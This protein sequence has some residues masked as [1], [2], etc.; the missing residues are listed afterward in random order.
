MKEIEF[1]IKDFKSLQIHFYT[2]GYPQ[3]GEAILTII[4]DK[5]EV[6]FTS[7]TDCYK[8]VSQNY[9]HI[10]AILAAHGNPSV[11]VFIWTH[12]D[13]DHSIGIPDVL[14]MYDPNHNALIY[15]PSAFDREDKFAICADA[16]CA[17]QYLHRNY[18]SG[19]KYN[20]IPVS[21]SDGGS[22]SLYKMKFVETR[23]FRSI[24]CSFNFLA[25]FGALEWRR[26]ANHAKFVMNDLSI[27]YAL[28][29]NG[30]DFL[31]CGDLANQS[32]KFIKEDFLQNV[33]FIK[34]PH[35]GSDEPI[36]FINKLVENQ[37]RN[38]ISTTTVY[39]N[40]L[41][42]QSVLEKYKNLNHDVY[43][44]GRGDSEFGCIKTTI[45]IVKLINNTSLTGNAYRLN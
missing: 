35:H 38:A 37:V 22:R 5:Q 27:V 45:N 6:L 43:C 29:F 44:T 12:P 31:F 18:N 14:E 7:L 16:T 40:N 2:V 28:R 10:N 26:S 23:S 20:I 3:E 34:I 11:N 25:P 17:F 15:M 9:N 42:V 41:P 39:Q 8:N 30:I 32:V 24:H 21:L 13:Q 33:L 4:C 1:S 36:S 19:C